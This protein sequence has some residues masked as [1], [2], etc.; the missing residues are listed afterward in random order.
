MKKIFLTA[1]ISSLGLIA[2]AQFSVTLVVDPNPPGS[3]INWDARTLTYIISNGTGAIRQ[4]VIKTV[5]TT[6]DG[7]PVATTNLAKARV[8]T[9]GPT[10]TLL[11]AADVMPLEIM[12]FVGK[13]KNSLERTGKLPAGSYNICVQLVTPTDFIPMSEERC[14]TF[15][16]ASIQLPIPMTPINEDV[17]ESEKAQTA[18]TFRW[19]PLAPTP[20]QPVKYI[21]TIFEVLDK[22]TP[23]QALR[24]NQPL[25]TKEVMGTTQFIWQ[26]QMSFIKTKIWTK[27]TADKSG[28]EHS[29]DP[30]EYT[31]DDLLR[32][33]MDS[34]DA[35]TF[36]WTIQ[37]IDFNHVPVGDGNVNG[38]GISEPSV[39]TVIRDGRKNKKGLPVR[40]IYMNRI[41]MNRN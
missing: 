14:R 20:K 24:S 12:V 41:N 21:V 22:Q 6:T 16:I 40:T 9:I 31:N 26:P 18:I 27:D 1:L 11:Y 7:T 10:N 36:I 3:I 39:F 29:G 8:I 37:T 4:A 2:N 38:D 35:T 25:L 33:A 34:I 23:M 30:H 32:Q 19:T 5:I 13:F 17:I 28:I 15:T